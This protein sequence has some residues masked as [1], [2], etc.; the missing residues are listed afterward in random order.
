[1][2]VDDFGIRAEIIVDPVSV[3]NRMNPSQWYEQ[4][5]LRTAEMIQIQVTNMFAGKDPKKDDLPWELAFERVV[6]F[7]GD[8][9][10]KWGELLRERHPTILDK[11]YLVGEV[12][13]GELYVQLTPFQEG[14]DQHLIAA[15][16]EKYDIRRTPL[17]FELPRQDGTLRHVRTKKE[18]LIGYEYWFAL[19][20]TPHMHCS[21]LAYVNQYHCPVRANSL[22][23]LMYPISQTPIRLGEDEIRNLSMVAGTDESAR[24][25]GTYANSLPAVTKLGEHLLFDK[26]PSRIERIEMTT[27]EIIQANSINNVV[28]HTFSCLG[29][30]IT[31]NVSKME[32][33][34]YADL[35]LPT[36]RR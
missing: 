35:E 9:N 8:V 19:Y 7:L 25:L 14:V 20:K 21:G 33:N 36:D 6:E 29:V 18:M 16:K 31:P 3:F 26:C 24:I 28:K 4:F 30:N 17:S 2:P 23:K 22:A 34:V 27:K 15:L 32:K 12:L 11:Q 1:M 5:L 10:P 13:R